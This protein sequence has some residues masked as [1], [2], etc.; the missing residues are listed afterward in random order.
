MGHGEARDAGLQFDFPVD[1][2]RGSGANVSTAADSTLSFDASAS[3]SPA[4]ATAVLNAPT[5]TPYPAPAAETASAAAAI[6]SAPLEAASSQAPTFTHAPQL[7]G[8]VPNLPPASGDIV[9][10]FWDIPVIDIPSTDAIARREKIHAKRQTVSS[11]AVPAGGLPQF[12]IGSNRTAQAATE[13]LALADFDFD[14]IISG[15][16]EA[17]AAKPG[18]HKDDPE[19]T[20]RSHAR[21]IIVVAIVLV[22]VVAVAIGG[23]I[24]W[25]QHR[26]TADYRQ[27][28]SAC[29]AATGVYGNA[30]AAL[31]T[32]L[33]NT[34]TMQNIPSNQVADA[35]TVTKLR[36]AVSGASRIG[37]APGC[38]AS[39]S[40]A[41][42]RESAQAARRLT[43]ALTTS[44]KSITSSA[45]A[46]TASKSVKDAA[47]AAAI[48][49]QLKSAAADAQA[50]FENSRYNVAD[51]ST[52]I[53][54]QGALK[55][56][57]ELLAQGKLDAAAAQDALTGLQNASDAVKASMNDLVAQN[58]IAAQQAQA[59]AQAQAQTHARVQRSTPTHTAP[60]GGDTGSTSGETAK[61]KEK[62]EPGDSNGNDKSPEGEVDGGSTDDPSG[63]NG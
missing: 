56:A 13:Q 16:S 60:A 59:Q 62:A 34:K 50:L 10:T 14:S 45:E 8:S 20:P 28:M 30:D 54:L 17:L 36:D 21:Q 43:A 22:I 29:S 9:D 27:A 44:A 46:V 18:T 24:I 26:D 42:L 3:V 19:L 15:S 41:A 1:S 48:F 7:P 39:M 57:N 4:A 11:Q 38:T 35:A 23:R 53:A 52:R 37:A 25:R 12:P 47:D 6:L 61:P 55:T 58:Q 31:N 5:H 2:S 49:E 33:R 63:P 40:A 32:V 51:D